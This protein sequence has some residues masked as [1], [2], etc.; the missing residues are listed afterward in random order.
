MQTRQLPGGRQQL[1]IT[2]GNAPPET[3]RQQQRQGR[4]NIGPRYTSN[5]FRPYRPGMTA[6]AYQN[7]GEDEAQLDEQEQYEQYEDT[8]YQGA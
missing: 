1:Q 4:Q 3:T 5:P 7:Y 8:F 2:N 6:R